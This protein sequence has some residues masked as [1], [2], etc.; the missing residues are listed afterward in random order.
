M[1]IKPRVGG[2]LDDQ[3]TV[4]S[5]EALLLFGFIIGFGKEVPAEGG[6]ALN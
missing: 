3:G 4:I 5:V 6:F 2:W 1:L